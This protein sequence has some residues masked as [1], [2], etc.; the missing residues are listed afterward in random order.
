M[1][2]ACSLLAG[3]SLACL[4]TAKNAPNIIVF[5]VFYG[6]FSGALLSLPPTCL[7][8]I[9]PHPSMIGVKLGVAMAVCSL[10]YVRRGTILKEYELICPRRLL[11]G[12]PI[13]GALLQRMHGD[14]SGLIAFSTTVILF[15]SVF[16][17]TARFVA[18]RNLRKAF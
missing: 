6:I 11:T 1:T 16:V 5:A 9:T 8:V 17:L 4:K 10:G 3:I 18:E 15:G 14:F 12:S 2:F 13:G 7:A